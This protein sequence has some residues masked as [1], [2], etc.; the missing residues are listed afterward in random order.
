MKVSLEIGEE[1]LVLLVP[2]L[3]EAAEREGLLVVDEER[4]DP[5]SSKDA[6][7]RSGLSDSSIRRLVENGELDRVPGISRLLITKDSWNRW[8]KGGSK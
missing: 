6:C 4:D 8:R 3:I 7:R 1:T 2:A 5:L